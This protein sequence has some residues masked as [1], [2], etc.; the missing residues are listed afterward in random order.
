MAPFAALFLV[1]NSAGGVF[2]FEEKIGRVEYISIPIIV[3]GCILTTLFGSHDDARV[4][5]TGCTDERLTIKP[6]FGGGNVTVCYC[7]PN[8]TTGLQPICTDYT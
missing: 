5:A 8:N 3:V 1:L 2:F 4:T 6:A 7:S